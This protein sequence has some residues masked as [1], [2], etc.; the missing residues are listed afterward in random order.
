MLGVKAA[1]N[2]GSQTMGHDPI[3]V[4]YH[5]AYISDIYIMTYNSSNITVVK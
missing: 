2:N 1:Y 3:G 4:A 5:T